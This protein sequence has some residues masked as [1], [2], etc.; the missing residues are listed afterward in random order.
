MDDA[1]I[2][3]DASIWESQKGFSTY[4]AKA[5]EQPLLLPQDMEGLRHT[6]Q[7]DLFM[8]LKRDLMMVS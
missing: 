5:L 7:L 4:F 6:K 3:W 8:S 2:S 1:P